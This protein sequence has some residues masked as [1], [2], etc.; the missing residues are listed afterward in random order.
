MSVFAENF[1]E[2]YL[3]GVLKYA[4][5]K[6]LEYFNHSYDTLCIDHIRLI[7]H[8]LEMRVLLD[9]IYSPN[10][11]SKIIFSAY[12]MEDRNAGE[13][14]FLVHHVN[15]RVAIIIRNYC[16]DSVPLQ[17]LIKGSIEYE[18]KEINTFLLKS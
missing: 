10:E 13:H 12:D 11:E 16:D 1:D 2:Q 5:L 4:S 17:Y 3:L 14:R 7:D 6:T 18:T 9:E 15:K 8:S